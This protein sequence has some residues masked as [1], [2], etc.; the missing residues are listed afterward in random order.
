MQTILDHE[1]GH[2]KLLRNSRSAQI[3]IKVGLDGSLKA[4]IP[5]HAPVF[6]LKRMIAS[7][8]SELREL[9]RASCNQNIT[10]HDGTAVGKSHSIIV[11][12]TSG[13]VATITRHGQ[14]II[15]SLPEN[16]QIEDADIQSQIRTEVIKALTK[17]A[18]SYL[19]RRL[20]YLADQHGFIFE[21]VRFSH[22][23]SRWGSCSSN[24]TISLNIALMK[25]PSRLIDYVLI[26]ELAHTIEM[27][28]S[29]KF[30]S[31]VN[32]C[33]PDYE[34]AKSEIKGFSPSI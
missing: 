15:V 2:I 22:A 16:V 29:Q 7:S 9:I 5:K 31:V 6:L 13:S 25:L 34:S 26:H 18:K 19:P 21:R 28:H 3:R 11:R 17:E 4:S 20:R 1:F 10:F 33:E 27:N 8:R 14:Q 12:K 32:R 30:W 24:G 23:S